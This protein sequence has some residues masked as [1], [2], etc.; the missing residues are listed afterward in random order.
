MA[1]TKSLDMD[2]VRSQFPALSNGWTFFDN[3]GGSQI[4]LSIA[5]IR[6]CMKRTCRLA[7]LTTC[8]KVPPPPC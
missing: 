6:F 4:L 5:S 7:D 1:P 3:A 2:F 8:H